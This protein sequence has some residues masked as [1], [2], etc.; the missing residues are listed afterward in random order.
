MKKIV[1]LIIGV[2]LTVLGSCADR[3]DLELKE[4]TFRITLN[5]EETVFTRSGVAPPMRYILEIY[6]DDALYLKQVQID[7][8]VF[9]FRLITNQS[10]DFLAWVDYVTDGENDYH[11]ETGNGL[12]NISLKNDDIYYNNDHTRD[13]FYGT[14]KD[15]M[16]T[17]S[18]KDFGSLICKRPFAQLNIKTLDWTYTNSDGGSNPAIKPTTI[19]MTFKAPANFNVNTGVTDGSN[20]FEYNHTLNIADHNVNEQFMTCDYIFASENGS[21]INPKIIFKS[22]TDDIITD[23]DEALYNLPLKRNYKTNVSGSLITKQGKIEVIVDAEWETPEFNIERPA[24]NT[25]MFYI[26]KEDPYYSQNTGI[27]TIESSRISKEDGIILLIFKDD[28]PNDVAI[29]MPTNMP[30][31]VNQIIIDLNLT[32]DSPALKLENEAFDGKIIIRNELLTNDPETEI[33]KININV[34]KATVNIEQNMIIN[35]DVNILAQNFILQ[36]EAIV[37]GNLTIQ[38]AYSS[39][40]GSVNG[41]IYALGDSKV[42][43]TKNSKTKSYW[44]SSISCKGVSDWHGFGVG[45]S[46]IIDMVL[47]SFALPGFLDLSFR[48]NYAGA[49]AAFN[50]NDQNNGLYWKDFRNVKFT[51]LGENG[52]TGTAKLKEDLY[53]NYPTIGDIQDIIN[54]PANDLK[55]ELNE[56]VEAIEE[57]IAKYETILPAQLY[58]ALKNEVTKLKDAVEY[59]GDQLPTIQIPDGPSLPLATVFPASDNFDFSSI[60]KLIGEPGDKFSLLDIPAYISGEKTMTLYMFIDFLTSYEDSANELINLTAQKESLE[61]EREL[62]TTEKEEIDSS[63]SGIKVSDEYLALVAELN[64]LIAEYD[65]MDKP[66]STWACLLAEPVKNILYEVTGGNYFVNKYYSIYG[67]P[68]ATN[69]A[70]ITACNSK[71]D[72][73]E[74]KV[75]EMRIYY[76]TAAGSYSNRLNEIDARLDEIDKAIYGTIAN[77]FTDGLNAQILA[78]QTQVTLLE[79]AFEQMGIDKETLANIVK[80]IQF[81]EPYLSTLANISNAVNDVMVAAQNYNIWEYPTKLGSKISII[82]I[83]VEAILEYDDNKLLYLYSK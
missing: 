67:T 30:G 62:L 39:I 8:G 35:N 80:V 43:I 42:D 61:A 65:S 75:T 82:N 41:T 56:K 38:D 12:K 16:I 7:N 4:N 70:K 63:L 81:V 28:F 83:E 5:P 64:A 73:I 57:M 22:S 9:D 14:M 2:F 55:Q 17:E 54:K 66:S 18:S 20:D 37:N 52:N 48:M 15:V 49:Y 78:A 50:F 44:T 72:E 33:E 32:T 1:Y 25:A 13:A 46:D 6:K 74:D 68:N 23:T 21:I 60:A 31:N 27:Y 40:K 47:P 53:L 51:F 76:N 26:T 79:S 19:N 36:E 59:F 24:G 71:I 11:Y 69:A 3:N 34:P 10:F 45:V 58:T 77:L 29:D